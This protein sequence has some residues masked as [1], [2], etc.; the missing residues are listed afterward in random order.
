MIREQLF[1]QSYYTDAEHRLLAIA[2]FLVS[3]HN[4]CKLIWA[5]KDTS[6]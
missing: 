2:K 4:L 3:L 6:S 5:F 1:L